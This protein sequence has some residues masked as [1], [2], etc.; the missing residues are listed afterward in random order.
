MMLL[1]LPHSAVNG[2]D[3]TEAPFRTVLR[4]VVGWHANH[5]VDNPVQGD[6]RCEVV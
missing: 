5:T 3:P 4:A 2:S 1:G 6:P